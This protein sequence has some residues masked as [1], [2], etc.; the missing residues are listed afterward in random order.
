MKISVITVCF[1]CETTIENTLLSVINQNY[2]EIEYIVIDG[3]SKDKTLEKINKYKNKISK[4]ISEK[5]YGIYDAINKGI[6]NSTGDIISLLH[7]NDIYFNQNVLF[8]VA[9]FF[10]KNKSTE[11]LLSDLAFKRNFD[12]NKISRYYS[13]KNFKPW[14]LRIG[15]SPPHLSSFFKSSAINKVGLYKTNYK[16]AGDFDYFVRAFLEHKLK[17]QYVDDCLIFMSTGG[18]S[19]KNL[20]SYLISSKEINASLKANMLY[21]NILLTFLRFPIKLIQFILK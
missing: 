2:K 9:E 4:I 11:L 6:K 16:I 15:L 20:D 13:A 14:M 5:D 1:N 10:K 21:S 7:G 18:T 12:Q 8:K 17:Y 3:G 19:G